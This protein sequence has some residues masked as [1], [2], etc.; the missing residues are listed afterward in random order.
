VLR[1]Q[2]VATVF[3]NP[4]DSIHRCGDTAASPI[5]RSRRTMAV[6]ERTRAHRTA[7]AEAR[8]RAH[9]RVAVAILT[10]N[11]AL[12]LGLILLIAY[13]KALLGRVV[14]PGLSLAIL[15]GAA[16]T[17]AAWLSTLVYVRW[18]NTFDRAAGRS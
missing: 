10:V 18:A 14:A 6:D 2:A 7:A 15:F 8:A 16:V 5:V 3:R 11:G 17:V 4:V 13:D 1:V 9:W 12:Y